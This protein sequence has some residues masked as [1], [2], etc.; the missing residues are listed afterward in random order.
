MEKEQCFTLGYVSKLQGYKGKLILRLDVDFPENYKN[1]ELVYL[2]KNSKLI[3]FFVDTIDILPKGYARVKFEDIDREEDAIALVKS[4]L[5]IPLE[6]LPKLNDNQFYYHEIIGFRVEDEFLGDIGSVIE[7]I[8]F[9]GN[10]QLSVKYREQEIIVPI[11]DPFYR[12]IDKKKKILYVSLPEG[13]VDVN[14]N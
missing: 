11:S 6:H 7:A 5:Y 12:G 8:D 13:L 3:P 2:E 1:L 4:E 14:L 9:P 10:P